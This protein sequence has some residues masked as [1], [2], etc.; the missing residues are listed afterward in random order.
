MAVKVQRP[1]VRELVEVCVSFCGVNA[2]LF[3]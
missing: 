1:G 3:H 2:H